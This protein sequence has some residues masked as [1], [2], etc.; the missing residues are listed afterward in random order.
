MLERGYGAVGYDAV[1][2]N[3]RHLVL[4][5]DLDMSIDAAVTTAEIEA[6][7]G[8]AAHYFVLLRTEMYNPW[9]DHGRRQLDRIAELGHEIGLHLNASLYPDDAAA[10]DRAAAE[11]CSVLATLTGRPVEMISFHRPSSALLGRPDDI[12]GR[13]HSYQPRYFHDIGYCSDSRGA[14]HHGHPFDHAAVGEGR[15]LQL[16][17]HP[18]WWDRDTARDPVAALDYFRAERDNVLMHALADNCEPY[19]AARGA[20]P[21]ESIEPTNG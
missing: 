19:R 21:D 12:A 18:I 10:L 2:P 16:L 5:H 7:L 20:S 17:T 13:S 3:A 15:A 9:S 8:V 6:E 11:E 4:R 14:W 1:A